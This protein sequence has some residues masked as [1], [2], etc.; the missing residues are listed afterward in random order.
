M[1]TA[2]GKC[3]RC[4]KCFKRLDTHLRVSATCRDVRRPSQRQ[5]APPTMVMNTIFST[6]NSNSAA[7]N[8]NSVT[9][10]PGNSNCASAVATTSYTT[11]QESPSVPVSAA[12]ALHFKQSLKLP[13]SSEEWDEANILVSAIAQSVTRATTVEET[14]TFLCDS[15]P[16]VLGLSHSSA[17]RQDLSQSLSSMIGP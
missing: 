15:S 11:T 1:P 5:T 7:S 12:T 13:K 8:L 10:L 6:A 2:R 17:P 14:N 4:G 16:A 3:S 9:T